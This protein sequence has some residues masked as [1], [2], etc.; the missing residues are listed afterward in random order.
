MSLFV[1]FLIGFC[2]GGLVGCDSPRL[3]TNTPP[4]IQP[5]RPRKYK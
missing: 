3:N 2:I 1:I 4:P 5:K